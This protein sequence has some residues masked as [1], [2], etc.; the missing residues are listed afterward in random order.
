VK[1]EIQQVGNILF[2]KERLKKMEG[3]K[4]SRL[5]LI[6]LSDREILDKSKE[7]GEL[8]V[9]LSSIESEKKNVMNEYSA[10]INSIKNLMAEYFNALSD[11]KEHREV[12]CVEVKN[13]N[14]DRIEWYYNEKLVDY[15]PIT[16]DDKQEE[17][18]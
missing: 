12:E 5:V 15:R 14:E 2:K 11:R 13:F 4:V 7:L 3:K 9:K 6:E 8:G 10:K 18:I 16:D 1:T 17:L